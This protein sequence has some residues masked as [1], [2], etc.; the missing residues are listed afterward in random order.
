MKLRNK[1]LLSFVALIIVIV[2][3]LF[4]LMRWSFDHGAQLYL[5]REDQV[6][7]QALS[8]ELEKFYAK[9]ASWEVFEQRPRLWL[10]WLAT[11]EVLENDL[12][13]NKK[14]RYDE[15]DD[16][17][18]DEA[19]EEGRDHEGK[20]HSRHERRFL[21]PFFL[22]D[23]SRRLV[24]GPVNTKATLSPIYAPTG[25]IVGFLGLPPPPERLRNFR[26]APLVKKQQALVFAFLAVVL[27][28]G[29]IAAFPLSGRMA[30][31]LLRL[32]EHVG[33]LVDGDYERS[34]HLKG[35][36]EISALAEHL[37]TL[38][39]T[40]HRAR[41]QRQQMTADISH[42]L[43]T[44]VATMQATIEAIQDG[45]LHADEK[46]LANLHLQ[47]SQLSKLINDLYQLSLAD[48]GDLQYQMAETP[49]APLLQA[50]V[51]SVQPRFESAGLV[52]SYTAPEQALVVSADSERLKQLFGNL[53]E[54][55]LR[56]TTA[57]GSVSV[58]VSCTDEQI[59]VCIEDS[60][61][62]VDPGLFDR[63][64]ER[65]FRAD[66]SRNRASGGAGLG[67]NLCA[68]IASAHGGRMA[69][70]TSPLGG[71]K[72]TVSFPKV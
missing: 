48:S 12:R 55:S 46:T 50:I 45:V 36:D 8:Q 1:L 64:T 60:A 6:Q 13:R 18:R 44:P 24:V 22:L 59:S 14:H 16:E 43:R 65:L 53:L 31:R 68:A 9:T 56:Y 62:G 32:H 71:L 51:E 33:H 38:S 69:F 27:V 40:L 20:H 37:N 29:V 72:V 34:V 11:Q 58:S 57:P 7:L 21:K 42:E 47:I 35:G 4:L 63:L 15:R 3:G 61:P 23:A 5:E 39:K 67:L 54:N 30:K 25:E 19:H 17:E 26:Q 49:I 70:D 66:A 28:I 41:I 2:V 10:R 52:L